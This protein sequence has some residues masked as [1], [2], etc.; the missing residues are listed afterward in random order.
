MDTKIIGSTWQQRLPRLIHLIDTPNSYGD[1]GDFLQLDLTGRKL[2]WASISPSHYADALLRDGTRSLLGNLDVAAG[3]TI[4]GVDL[5]ALQS[6]Y[7]SHTA[8]VAAHHY[9]VSIGTGGL[10]AKLGLATQVLT[11]AA[12]DHHEIGG[13]GDDDHPQYGALAQSE[14]VTGAWAFQS[15]LTTRHIL[16]AAT[17]TYDLGSATALWRKGWLSELESILF[18]QNSVQVTGGWWM[19]PHASGTLAADV[20]NAQTTVNFGV[21]MTLNDFILLRG[22]LQVEYMKVGTLVSGTTYNVTRNLDGSG[23][24]VWPQGQVFVVLGNTGDGRIEFDAQ[25]AGPRL[26]IFEQ[27]S[28]YNVQTERVRIGDLATWGGAGLTGYGWAAGDYAGGQYAY[29]APGSGLVVKGTVTASSGLIGGWTLTSTELHN[30]NVWLD[31]A[32]KQL[33]VGSQTFGADGVQLE[34]NAGNPRAYIGNGGSYYLKFDGAN[35][36]WAGV[37]TSLTAAGA[38][39]ATSATIT[40]VITATGGSFSGVLSIGASGGVYQGSGTFASPTTGLKLWND[41][42]VGRIA[43]YNGGTLQVGFGTDGKLY[44]GGGSVVIDSNGV[45]IG[46]GATGAFVVGYNAT[47]KAAIYFDAPASGL[48]ILNLSRA[49][50]DY[51]FKVRWFDGATT[52]DGLT[53]QKTGTSTST[54]FANTL[55]LSGNLSAAGTATVAGQ[56]YK[57]VASVARQVNFP[58]LRYSETL[59]ANL[60]IEYTPTWTTVATRSITVPANATIK[61]NVSSYWICSVFTSAISIESRLIID[62]TVV[63]Y[64]TGGAWGVWERQAITFY[65]EKDVASGTRVVLLQMMKSANVNTVI[66]EGGKTFMFTE[67]WHR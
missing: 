57:T 19:V 8:D 38:F 15:D 21:A 51:L 33:A 56:L 12:I 24:N 1:P 40:G 41:S 43:T 22:N 20:N 32:A 35:I 67:V 46:N 11:L 48:T 10:S 53:V 59:S 39:T 18:V 61:V 6:A 36:S 45:S 30:T 23:A 25:T 9:P 29:Y 49:T 27:S 17:D 60:T 64:V 55:S 58:Y 26:S 62:G 65:G 63:G 28:S 7:N 34:Y 47:D 54:C 16:P 13:L 3:V 2:E 31:A 5:S 42:G 52:Y 66:A 14:V 4:D 44:A 50:N 37:N